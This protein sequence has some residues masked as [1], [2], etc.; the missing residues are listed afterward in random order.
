MNESL[1]LRLKALE[2]T[3]GGYTQEEIDRACKIVGSVMYNYGDGAHVYDVPA[4]EDISKSDLE[5][6]KTYI[7]K[8]KEGRHR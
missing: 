5:F 1:N 7:Q 8:Y 6:I 4:S 2:K 3:F